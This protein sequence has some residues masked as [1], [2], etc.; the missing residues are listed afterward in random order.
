MSPTAAG[1]VGPRI[2]RS[3]ST[4]S[5]SGIPRILPD[6]WRAQPG[7]IARTQRRE[8]A[9]AAVRRERTRRGHFLERDFQHL[10]RRP[11]YLDAAVHPGDI[12]PGR[13]L[14]IGY[15]SRI[16]RGST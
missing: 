13:P 16:A 7:A 3:D 12:D 2:R 4:P 8:M 15:Y 5:G 11:A 9:P 6:V 14:S 10:A 1:T